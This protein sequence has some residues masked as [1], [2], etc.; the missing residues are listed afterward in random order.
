MA[1][2]ANVRV[3]ERGQTIGLSDHDLLYYDILLGPKEDVWSRPKHKCIPEGGDVTPQEWVERTSSME[4]EWDDAR[5]KGDLD[6]MWEVLCHMGESALGCGKEGITRAI[7]PRPRKTQYAWRD[8]ISTRSDDTQSKEHHAM[9]KAE[10]CAL[11]I[12][13]DGSRAT[14]EQWR[15][16]EKKRNN[17]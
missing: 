15:S 11:Q 12:L 17:L 4:E 8:T 16:W 10:R 9:W 2:N 13:R 5:A 7:I 14:R 6:Q 1:A 3:A